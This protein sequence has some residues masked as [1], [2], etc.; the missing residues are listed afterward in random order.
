MVYDL[1]ANLVETGILGEVRDVT[2]HLAIDLDV[3][4]H[5]ATVGLETTV[6]VVEVVNA[7]DL[8]GCSVE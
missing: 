6:E 3:L 8:T 1:L 7:A 2:V 4:D 5:I